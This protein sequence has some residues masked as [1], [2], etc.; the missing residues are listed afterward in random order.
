MLFE[1]LLD[2]IGFDNEKK[3]EYF[4]YQDMIGDKI[5]V[6]SKKYM[7]ENMPMSEA[8]EN[9][10]KFKSEN[11][12]EYTIDLVFLLN[13]TGFLYDEYRKKGIS[14]GIFI[15]TMKDI[16]YKV[17]ECMKFKGIFGT[18]VVGWFDG[19]FKLDRLG[20]GRL[21]YD[22]CPETE[23]IKLSKYTINAGDFVLGCHIPSAGPLKHELCMESYAMAYNLFK[24]RLK[25]GILPIK[26]HSWLLYPEYI[27]VFQKA[28]KNIFKFISDF[29]I[30]NLNKQE[31]F[32]DAW[33]IFYTDYDGDT[34][35]LS[36]ETKLQR[37]MREHIKN[38]GTFG[39]GQGVILFDGKNV[40]TQNK[41]GKDIIN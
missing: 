5:E 18:F 11:I 32:E 12:S 28:C 20:L 38:G 19:F 35:K 16:L 6:Y 14:E 4:K 26:C 23:E 3:R 33:R 1:N 29:E 13:S 17:N 34:D 10:H 31:K 15:N 41:N 7:C 9:I 27:K 39:E 21:Q 2:K 30:Y 8:L 25:D 36:G 40:I 24:D 37:E 22:I